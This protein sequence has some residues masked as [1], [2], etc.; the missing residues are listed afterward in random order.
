MDFAEMVP[1]WV[2]V[3]GNTLGTSALK[4]TKMHAVEEE[5][6]HDWRR[7]EAKCIALDKWKSVKIGFSPPF[8]LVLEREVEGNRPYFESHIN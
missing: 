8:A 6:V 1:I 2:H 7:P 5:S 3:K 4:V